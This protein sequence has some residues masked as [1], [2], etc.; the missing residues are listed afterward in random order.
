MPPLPGSPL[1]RVVLALCDFSPQ[2]AGD[3]SVAPARY[4]TRRC[5]GVPDSEQ[6]AKALPVPERKRQQAELNTGINVFINI[7]NVH[8]RTYRLCCIRH[9]KS[10]PI[11][12][13]KSDNLDL[14]GQSNRS[15]HVLG[16]FQFH[17]LTETDLAHDVDIASSCVYV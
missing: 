16:G 15:A 11:H 9:I 17:S 14:D 3:V 12:L 10:Y 8:A 7:H 13:L 1:P 2:S 6:K 5:R 4:S